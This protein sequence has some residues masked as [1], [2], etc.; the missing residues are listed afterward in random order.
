MK[1]NTEAQLSGIPW[2]ASSTIDRD[3]KVADAVI[4]EPLDSGPS[5]WS[6]K[7]LKL[8][9]DYNRIESNINFKKYDIMYEMQKIEKLY[10]DWKK[11]K[12]N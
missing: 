11:I 10:K 6:Q 7:I 3:I 12:N 4:F 5:V 8:F 2:I 9:E 1:R